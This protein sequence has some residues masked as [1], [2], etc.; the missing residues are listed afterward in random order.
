MSLN[1]RDAMNKR[2]KIN[3]LSLRERIVF[4]RTN[5]REPSTRGCNMQ[6][7]HRTMDASYKRHIVQRTPR[8]RDILSRDASYFAKYE[9][10]FAGNP[11]IVVLRCPSLNI[12][13]TTVKSSVVV[14][15]KTNYTVFA[16]WITGFNIWLSYIFPS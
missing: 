11:N 10:S 16:L 4:G 2:G 15:E 14:C 8:A 3:H 9:T 12:Q 5:H 1:I 13:Y 6:D 7:T